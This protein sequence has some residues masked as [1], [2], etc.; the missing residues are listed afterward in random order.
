VLPALLRLIGEKWVLVVALAASTVEMGLLAG[1]GSGAAVYVGI[2]VGTLGSMA[3]PGISALKSNLS[4]PS[5]Q[6]VV[7]V[8]AG[9]GQC[10]AA[11]TP[12]FTFPPPPRLT[13]PFCLT[14]T[15]TL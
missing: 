4:Q 5:E 2:S 8:S 6:G 9:R 3:F 1:A 14:P 7:Q 11:A 10:A 12:A 15:S 13:P